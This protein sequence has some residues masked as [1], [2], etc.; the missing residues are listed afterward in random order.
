MITICSHCKWSLWMSFASSLLFWATL[1]F[2]LLLLFLY[3]L[4]FSPSSFS[5]CSSS[6]P[7]F[8]HPRG[9]DLEGGEWSPSESINW[10][11]YYPSSTSVQERIYTKIVPEGTGIRNKATIVDL[12]IFDVKLFV[13]CVNHENEKWRIIIT[14]STYCTHWLDSQHS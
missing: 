10:Y 12:E 6:F 7:C 8:G 1:L 2:L 5:P 11:T 4:L 13:V 9:F 3:S 14:V